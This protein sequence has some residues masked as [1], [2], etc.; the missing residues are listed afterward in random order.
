MF[1]NMFLIFLPHW[2]L[3]NQDYLR[4]CRH[5]S[6]DLIVRA[7]ARGSGWSYYSALKGGVSITYAGNFLLSSIHND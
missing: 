1:Y 2:S 6:H 4:Q 5:Q 3:F 7:E